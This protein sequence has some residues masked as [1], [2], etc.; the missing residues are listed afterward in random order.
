MVT[1]ALVH[2]AI[3]HFVTR[4]AIANAIARVVAVAI[5]FVSVQQRSKVKGNKSDGNCNKKG[6]GDGCKSNGNSD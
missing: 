5:S 6:V 3:A 4:N 2:L 1:I